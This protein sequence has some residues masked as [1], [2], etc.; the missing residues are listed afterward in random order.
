MNYTDGNEARAGDLISIAGKY[1]GHVVAS[2]DRN[3]YLPGQEQW[4]YLKVGIMVD[5]DFGGLVHYTSEA[6]ESMSLVQRAKT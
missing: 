4:S 2:M 1:K 3:E 6:M 5:T